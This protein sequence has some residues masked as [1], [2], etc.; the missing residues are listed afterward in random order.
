MQHQQQSQFG[1]QQGAMQ[2]QQQSQFGMQQAMSF[3]A[4][5]YNSQQFLMPM[6]P[7]VPQGG[8][9]DGALN[10]GFQQQQMSQM[11]NMFHQHDGH[12]QQQNDLQN[13]QQI[14]FNLQQQKEGMQQGLWQQQQQ[15]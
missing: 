8:Y 3:E 5:P 4:T 6:K 11:N 13:L 9:S 1:M 7:D 14:Q 2:H 12:V 15:Q 10:S